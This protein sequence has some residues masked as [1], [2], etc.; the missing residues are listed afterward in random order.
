M[1]RSALLGEEYCIGEFGDKRLCKS[2]K[3]LFK[4]MIERGTVCI[5]QLCDERAEQKRFNR[6]LEHLSVTHQEIIRHGGMKLASVVAGRH[7][8]AIQD[9]SELDYTAHSRRTQGLGRITNKKGA[10][11]FIHPML[12][13]DANTR[14]CLG[15]AHQEAWIRDQAALS[16]SSHRP[17][18][19][20]ESYCWLKAVQKS[21]PYLER[22]ARITVIADRESDIYE[23]WDRIPSDR[24][25]L[26]IRSNADRRLADGSTLSQWVSK[27]PVATSF[28]LDVPVRKAGSAYKSTKGADSKSRTFHCARMV[29]RFGRVHIARPEHCKAKQKSIELSVID[30]MELPDTVEAGEE[31]VH[32]RLL[33]THT[34]DDVASALQIVEWYRQRWQIEQLFRTLKR[35]GLDVEASQLED[36]RALLKLVSIAVLVAAR[37][38][39]LVNAR[40]GQTTQPA[41][42]AFDDD[43]I[44]LI[45]KLHAKFEGKTPKQKNPYVARTMA[46][47]S[48]LIARLG[49]WM[50]YSSESKPGPITM[51]HGLQRFDSI[52]LGWKL[53]DL[54]A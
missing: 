42:D 48:W 13:V 40:D 29:L 8:L 27:Q 4:R 11:L 9:T 24:I 16:K 44:D 33:T 31:P 1:D 30:V 18:E 34:V 2:G 26:L 45:E 20:K 22:A 32:W 38:L 28:M 10:G 12:I 54:R 25:D 52:L 36:A 3:L 5:R 7:V 21:A 41:G 43:E 47:A 46:W 35:Q 50:G 15:V 39:Q 17:I 53:L 14:D 49:G 23:E 19:E 6:L 51:L 37:T